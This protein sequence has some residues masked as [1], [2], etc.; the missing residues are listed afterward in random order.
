M[1]ENSGLNNLIKQENSS[2]VELGT[3]VVNAVDN[4]KDKIINEALVK[5]DDKHSIDKHAKKLADVADKALKADIDKEDL[6]VEKTKAE[7]KAEKQEIKNRLIELK[8]EAKRLKREHKQILKEQKADHKKRNK[9]ILWETYK[10]KLE[11][12]K[13]TY[14]P[15]IVILKMLLGID[16]I[17]SFFDGI[18]KISTSIM[19]ALKW[20]IIAGAVFG[21]LMIFPSTKE[22]ILGLL[23]F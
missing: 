20:I 2:Q 16:G 18:G 15:N 9:D 22:W 10:E 4:V 3:G 21:V 17:V 6:K 5:V 12:M 8:T 19:K 1:E 23:G 11:K 7:N 14:V 13:Y